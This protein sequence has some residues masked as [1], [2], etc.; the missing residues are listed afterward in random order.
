MLPRNPIMTAVDRG[1]PDSTPT[2]INALAPAHRPNRLDS[3]I[4]PPG[5]SDEAVVGRCRPLAGS[6]GDRPRAPRA[7]DP[8]PVPHRG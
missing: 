3:P 8:R 6:Q 7:D 2:A 1:R 5:L 4:L